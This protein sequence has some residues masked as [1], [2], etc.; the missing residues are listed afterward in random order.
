MRNDARP[1]GEANPLESSREPRSAIPNPQ[2]GVRDSTDDGRESVTHDRQS[3][4][5]NRGAQENAR[6]D[7]ADLDPVMPT[8]DSSLNTKI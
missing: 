4:I 5:V 6:R 1:I 2:S 3:H 8:G 7:D